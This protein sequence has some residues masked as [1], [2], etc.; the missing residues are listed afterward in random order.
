MAHFGDV[1]RIKRLKANITQEQIAKELGCQQ[2]VIAQYELNGKAPNV[3]VAYKI[4]QIL[5]SS[6][7]EMLTDD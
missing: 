6:L 2:S 4:A 7:D 1:M 5:G 3:Y